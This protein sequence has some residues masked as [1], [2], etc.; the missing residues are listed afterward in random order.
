MKPQLQ[1]VLLN[2]SISRLDLDDHYWD[3]LEEHVM[4]IELEQELDEDGNPLLRRD[5][6]DNTQ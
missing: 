3:W 5:D 2:Q 1:T 4:E 6:D